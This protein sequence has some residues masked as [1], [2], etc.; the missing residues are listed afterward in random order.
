MRCPVEALNM[1]TQPAESKA[2]AKEIKVCWIEYWPEMLGITIGIIVGGA[3][4]WA[5]QQFLR[6]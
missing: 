4:I 2:V 5:L 6:M 3:I 1:E